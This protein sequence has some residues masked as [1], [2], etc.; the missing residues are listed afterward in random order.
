M[1]RG[2]WRVTVHVIAQSDTEVIKQQ[3]WQQSYLGLKIQRLH[4]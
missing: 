4:V 2:A 3:Q 1:D